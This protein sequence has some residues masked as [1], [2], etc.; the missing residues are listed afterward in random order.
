MSSLPTD[1][2]TWLNYW[3]KVELRGL[4]LC[5]EIL[6][7]GRRESYLS[8]LVQ[9]ERRVLLRIYISKVLPMNLTT[10]PRSSSIADQCDKS[11]NNKIAATAW[12]RVIDLTT[13]IHSTKSPDWSKSSKSPPALLT[14]WSGYQQSSHD[15]VAGLSRA[16]YVYGRKF[17]IKAKREHDR[18]MS[19]EKERLG[20]LRK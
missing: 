12:Q 13:Q 3:I 19:V 15:D 11:H 5:K 2:E 9:F 6:K 17:D 18:N 10:R 1:L 16:T 8:N 4:D 20:I 14:S 7:I